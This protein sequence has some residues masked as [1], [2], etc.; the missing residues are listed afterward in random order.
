MHDPEAIPGPQNPFALLGLEAAYDL[1]PRALERRWLQRSA[2]LHPDR[3]GDDAEAAR[4]LARVNRA[5]ATLSDPESRANAL[6][7]LLGGPAKEDDKSLPDG[8]LME[9]FELR[10]EHASGDDETRSRL[11]AWGEQRRAEHERAIASMFESL[12]DPPSEHELRAIRLEL[13]AWRY[14]ERFLADPDLV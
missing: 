1:D 5:K 4:E 12:S 7:S 3:V 9:M 10:D 8:F 2:K 6:L 14:I 11:E 13:N